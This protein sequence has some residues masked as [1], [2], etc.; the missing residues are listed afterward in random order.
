[1]TTPPYPPSLHDALPIYLPPLVPAYLA[2]GQLAERDRSNRR[3]QLAHLSGP[4]VTQRQ[5]RRRERHRHGQLIV[6]GQVGDERRNQQ[7]NR[8]EEHTSELQSRGHLVW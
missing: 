5:L 1:A 4:V 2:A 7:W 8:S 6:R 3:A